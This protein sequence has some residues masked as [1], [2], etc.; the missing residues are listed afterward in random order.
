MADHM[1]TLTYNERENLV[2][3]EGKRIVY[4]EDDMRNRTLTDMILS[5]E[6]ARL[7]FER[8]GLPATALTTVINH[9]PLDMILLD[10]MFPNGYTGYDIFAE[11]RM[12]PELDEV[13]IVMVSASDAAIEIPRAKAAG[14]SAYIPKPIDAEIFPAQLKAIMEGDTM[15][16]NTPG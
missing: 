5:A 12:V 11:L 8:W 14:L 13:P 1:S 15:W 4:I 2:I 3:L 7:W 9:L 6:G 10:L 16:L